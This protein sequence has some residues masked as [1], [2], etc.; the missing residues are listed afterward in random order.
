MVFKFEKWFTEL[1]WSEIMSN[2]ILIKFNTL[3][4]EENKFKSKKIWYRPTTRLHFWL[5]LLLALYFR[6]VSYGYGGVTV[7]ANDWKEWF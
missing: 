6:L 4:F 7:S 3:F 5:S 1:K 2:L